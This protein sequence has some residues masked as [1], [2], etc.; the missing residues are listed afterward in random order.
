[1][2]Q[3]PI[4][5]VLAIDIR[6]QRIGYAAFEVA[7]RLLDWGMRSHEL[8]GAIAV[9][10]RRFQPSVVVLRRM[11]VGGKRD[12]PGARSIMRAIRSNTRRHSIPLVYLGDAALNK[13]F[14]TYGEQSKYEIALLLATCFPELK[15]KLPPR[16]KIWMP[17]HLRMSIFDAVQLGVVFL[18]TEL[19]AKAMQHLMTTAEVHSQTSR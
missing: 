6:S 1:M 8:D 19:D 17:E 12:T 5:R 4:R 11:K 10:L 3:K 16:R 7:A 13:F 15:W 18:A 9:L 2:R 14:R